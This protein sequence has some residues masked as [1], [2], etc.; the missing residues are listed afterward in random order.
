MSLAARVGRAIFWSQAGRVAE[1]LLLFL[2]SLLLARLLGPASYGRYAVGMGAA[3]LCGFLVLLGLGPETLGRFLPEVVAGGNQNRARGLLVQLAAI[4]GT[5]I[6]FLAAT[7]FHFREALAAWLHFSL[8][9]DSIALVLMVFAAKSVADLL[10]YFSAGLLEMQRVAVAKVAAALTAPLLM[11]LF[12]WFRTANPNAAWLAT[13]GGLFVAI[14]VLGIPFLCIRPHHRLTKW[15]PVKRILVFGMF[16][17]I[18]VLF[19]YVLG[20]NT[21]VMLLGWLQPDRIAIGQYAVGAKIAFSLNALLLGWASLVSVSSLSEAWQEGGSAR[22][23]RLVE[24]Q[25]KLGVLS[26]VGPSLLLLRYAPEIVR[27]FYSDA[28]APSAPVIQILCGLMALSSL[29]GFTLG[30]S[31]L[32]ATS[33]ERLACGLVGA[34]AAFNVATE[35]ILVRRIGIL[36]A[37]WATGLSFIVLAMISA[38]IGRRFFPWRFPAVFT[39]KV[40]LACAIALAPTFWI[41]PDSSVMLAAGMMAWGVAFVG[42]LAIL[43]PLEEKDSAALVRVNPRLAGLAAFFGPRAVTVAAGGAQWRE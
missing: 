42:S 11:F 40:L 41:H 22:V 27:T 30:T 9:E 29:L 20:D 3:G 1:A 4:R 17:W 2:F 35:I 18:T 37:A 25:W 6:I 21:D 19:V 39:G 23:A 7:V 43:K 12:W 8:G 32:Y 15:F 16:T 34:A 28:Y 31:A 33:H 10:T 13:T 38:V 24:G 14:S 26:L 36:G 5:A